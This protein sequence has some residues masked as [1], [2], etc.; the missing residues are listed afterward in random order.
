MKGSKVKVELTYFSPTSGKYYAS[1]E[2]ETN[3]LHMHEVFDEV[4]ELVRHRQLPGL[5]QGHG[6]WIVSISV[7]RHPNNHP[8]LVIP[9]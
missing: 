3:R 2:Y 5:V 6:N 1:G 7:P 8:H 9:Y 4:A